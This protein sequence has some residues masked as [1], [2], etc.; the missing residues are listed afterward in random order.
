MHKLT[1]YRKYFTES[2]CF[3]SGKRQSPKGVQVH[4]TGANNPWLR[5][6]VGPDDGRL[7]K[8]QYNNHSNQPGSDVC[9][10]AYIGKLANGEIA[11][12]QSLPWDMRCW[13]S[14][15]GSNG[16]ANV[17][18]YIGFEICEDGLTD[19]K[20]FCDVMHVAMLLTAH[21]CEL[22]GRMPDE[23][24]ATGRYVVMDHAEMHAA[25]IASNHGDIKHWLKKY[26]MNM[27][28]F[29]KEVRKIMLEGIE[30]TYVDASTVERSERPILRKGS[31]GAEVVEM[32][33]LLG[34]RGYALAQDGIFGPGTMAALINFQQTCGISPDG[35]CGP[36]T[37][38]ALTN[39]QPE[40]E[41]PAQ[42]GEQ[43]DQ[44]T[45]WDELV[46]QINQEL[47]GNKEH[48][49]HMIQ[50]VEALDRMHKKEEEQHGVGQSN[51]SGSG[52]CRR[53]GGRCRRM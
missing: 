11:V 14:G 8:N 10:S 18:G 50:M 6:Y 7:G 37:W 36:A 26:G 28:S 34:R 29:R 47:K 12:Y 46:E 16:N 48:I 19:E 1:I 31:V 15:S 32:Q 53:G 22:I 43:Q 40:Q 49:E 4:S 25:G 3:K 45:A 41:Q 35:I 42:D 17:L 9:A 39:N 27:D 33:Q 23:L 20:Y 5:R 21:L 44:K 52:H 30:V 38:A 51:K 24:T 13:L 2:D